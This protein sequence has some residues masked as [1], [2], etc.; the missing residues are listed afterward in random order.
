MEKYNKI[1]SS[2]NV[3]EDIKPSQILSLIWKNFLPGSKIIDLGCGQ[4]SDSLF[5][6]K[7]NFS[8]TAIDSSGVAI[9]Q[10]KAKKDELKFDNL[11]PICSDINDFTIERDKYQVI[12][13]RNVLNFLDKNQAIK[14][15]QNIKENIKSGGHIIIETFTEN[16]PSFIS[17]S[18]FASYFEEQELLKIFTGFKI[19]YYLENTILDP[20]HL[21][22][23]TPHKHGVARIIAQR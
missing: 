20:G 7:N 6:A 5:L 9:G 11:E 1:Y 18:K 13:C 15:I 19:I 12:I 16:D 2:S 8:V 22:F 21:G 17:D 14:I 23:A 3:S 10:I 4:G